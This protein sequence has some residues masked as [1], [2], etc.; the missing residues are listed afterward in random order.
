[1][2]HLLASHSIVS[3]R[4][5][6]EAESVLSR[7]LA[8][9]RIK[10][11]RDRR[12][13]RFDM[14]GVHL[15]RTMIGYNRFATDTVVDPGLIDDAVLLVMGVGPSSFFEIDGEPVDCTKRLVVLSPGKRV[16][17]HRP[18]ASGIFILRAGFD[19]IDER[20]QEVMGREPEKPLVFGSSVD[21]ADRVGA[22]T[23]RLVCSLIEDIERDAVVLENSLLRAGFDDLLLSAILALPNNYTEDLIG[24]RRPYVTPRLVRRAEG[25]LEAHATEPITISDVVAQCSCSRTALRNVSTTLRQLLTGVSWYS[26]STHGPAPETPRFFQA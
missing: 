14:N 2:E 16:L 12:A 9:L 8:D 26:Q 19:A 10:K 18:A 6:D 24:D 7:E 13:F 25:Y 23:R 20:F 1:M 15:G 21:R 11:V 3:T 22:Q 4:D 17:I 5:A